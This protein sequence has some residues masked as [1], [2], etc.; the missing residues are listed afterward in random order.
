MSQKKITQLE[1]CAESAEAMA[2]IVVSGKTRK[3][4]AKEPLYITRV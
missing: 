2:E 3:D 1:F 4:D